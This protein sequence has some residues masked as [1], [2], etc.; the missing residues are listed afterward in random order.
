MKLYIA[1]KFSEKEQI[2]KYMEEAIK[3][4]HTITHDW[5]SFENEG[6]DKERMK[7]SAEKDIIGV[8]NCDCVIA[9]LTDPKYAYRGTWC[10]IGCSMGLGKKVIMVNPNKDAYCTTNCFY[11][12]PNIVHVDNW[13]DALEKLN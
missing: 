8:Q 3:L 4:G 12:H 13:D 10:E 1:G 6:D 7:R 5:T 11:H 2:K 9:I